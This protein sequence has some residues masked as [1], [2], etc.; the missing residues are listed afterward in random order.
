MFFCGQ[1]RQLMKKRKPNFFY[2]SCSGGSVVSPGHPGQ[3]HLR[4]R[5]RSVRIREDNMLPLYLGYQWGTENLTKT[6]SGPKAP[7][8]CWLE[9]LLPFLFLEKNMVAFWMG[10]MRHVNFFGGSIPRWSFQFILHSCFSVY[11]LFGNVWK[12]MIIFLAAHF[13]IGGQTSPTSS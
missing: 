11:C 4:S 7:Q 12:W 5:G 3:V 13:W 6:N 1:S 9:N 10:G 2:E 8:K